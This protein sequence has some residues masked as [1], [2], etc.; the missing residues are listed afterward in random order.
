METKEILNRMKEK[1]NVVADFGYDIYQMA[2]RELA[3]TAWQI[4]NWY[5]IYDTLQG[6][7]KPLDRADAIMLADTCYDM[8]LGS[9]VFELITIAKAVVNLLDHDM[10]PEDIENED[11]FEEAEN[12]FIGE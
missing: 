11:I 5:I 8:Y 10:L 2:N 9:P 3:C 4:A 12:V 6:T 1:E 7:E